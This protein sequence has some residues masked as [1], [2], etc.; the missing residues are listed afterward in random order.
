M[1]SLR[2]I[3]RGQVEAGGPGGPRPARRLAG[4]LLLFLGIWITGSLASPAL[5]QPP[6]A[7]PLKKAPAALD[8][9]QTFTILKI[10]PDAANEEVRIIFSHPVSLDSLRGNLRLLPFVKLDWRKSAAKEATVTL[11]GGFKY[12]TGYLVALPENLPAGGRTYNPTI[13]SFVMP[14]RPPK[15]EFVG[16]K[17]VIERDS[18]QL[19]HVKA[20]NVK[21]L[22]Y[23]GLRIPPLL[24]PLA[25]A[26]EENPADWDRTRED[27]K[28]GA[29]KLQALTRGNKSFLPFLT[30]PLEEKQLF[31]APA[32]KNRLMAVSL[33]LSFRQNKEAGALELIR[34]RQENGGAATVPRV[35]RVTDLGLTYKNGR[36]GLLIW[37]TSLKDGVPL[38]GVQVLGFTRDM[39]V[40]PL[41]QTDQDGILLFK[42]QEAQGLS[43]ADLAGIK[44]VKREVDKDQLVCLLAGGGRDFSFI[45]L[46]PQGNLKPEGIWQARVEDTIRSLKGQV[47]TER[48][49][50]RPGEKVFFKGV[51]REYREGRIAP[52]AEEVCAFEVTSPKDESVF[53]W[54]GTLSDFG[55]V[56]GEIP[57][58]SHWPL[59]TYT[60]N[61]TFGPQEETATESGRRPRGRHRRV[62]EGEAAKGP[63][64]KVTCTFQVQE[65]KPPRHF[66]SL[67]F[68]R[69]TRA[70]KGYVNQPDRTRE[71]VRIGLSGAYYVGGPVKH[72]QVIWKIY[73]ARTSYT[74]PAYDDFTFGYAGQEKK[75]LIEGGQAILDEKGRAEVEFP[76]EQAVL[77]GKSG[78]QVTATV[79]DFDG[80]SA[81]DS[82]TFQIDPDYLV[83]IS[84]HPDEISAGQD[85]V[86]KV[87]VTR[88][89]GKKIKTGLIRAEVL[90]QS[91]AYVAKRNDQ[92]D[93]YWDYQE[94]W[95]KSH[96]ADLPLKQGEA[97]FRFD[98]EWGGRYLVAF[99]YKDDKGRS[100]ASAT[101]FEVAYASFYEDRERGK[102]A[103][104]ELA[105]FP[106]RAA[107]KPGQTATIA[108]RPKG[109]VSRYLVTLEQGGLLSHQ[110]ITPG[111]GFKNLEIPIRKEY[112]P[113]VFVSVLAL[114]PRGDFPVAP[115]SYDTEA[116]NFFWGTLNLPVRLEVEPLEVK[117]SPE[118]KE[119]KAEPGSPFKLDFIVQDSKG[120]GVEAELAV[121]VVDEAVL[122]LTGFKTPVLDQLSRFDGPLGVYTGELRALLVHQTPFYLARNEPLTGGGGL[123]AEMAA[124]LRKRFEAVAYYNP[125]V[126]TDAKGR[127]QVSFTLPDNMTSYRVY[128]VA[129][130]RGARFASP[131]RTLKTPK[132]FYLEPG[133]PSFFTQGDR[134]TFQTAAFNQTAAAGPVKFRVAAEGGLSLKSEGAAAPL[135]A[136][137]SLKIPVSGEA[138]RAGPATARV[139]AEFQGRADSVELKLRVNSG[140]VRETTLFSGSLTGTREIKV[141]LPA[142]LT[143]EAAG[144]INPEEVKAVL[145]LS[146]SP[147]LRMAGAIQYLLTYPYGCVEQASSGVLALAALRGLIKDNQIEGV[148]LEQTDQYLGAGV[149]RI[150]SMQTESGGFGYWPGYREAHSLGSLYAVAALSVA[151]SQG[152]KVSESSLEKAGDYLKAQIQEPQVPDF[153]KAFACYL[154]ALNRTLDLNL[155]KRVSANYA[156]L[157]REGKIL[158]L[159]AGKES[160]LLK[161]EALKK[162]LGPLLGP[163]AAGE[164]QGDEFDARF[165]GPALA[166][167]AAKAIMPEDPRTKQAALFL[168]GGLDHQGIWT[169]TSDTGWALLALGEYYKGLT[170]SAEPSEVKV[171]QPGVKEGPRLTL[172]P[173]G[174]RTVGLE[175]QALLKNPV[176]RVEAKEGRTWLYKL[177][178]TAPRLDIAATG[179]DQGFK[180]RKIIKNT[181]GS[182]EIKVG[183]LVKVTVLIDVAG[184]QGRYV[185]LEDPLPAGLAAINSAFKTE[186]PLPERQRPGYDD[187]E[188]NGG[189][190]S[191]GDQFEYINPEG[192][193]AFRPNYFEIRDDRVLAFRDWVFQGP[194]RFEYYAR[195]VCQGQFAVPATKA[196]AM[197]SPG[198][199]GYSPQGTITIQG[200]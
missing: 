103:Y 79:V 53:T 124:R 148:T 127:A 71:F 14:D 25:L 50:Y 156:R 28:T 106:N 67:D 3:F 19:L 36:T 99:T 109:A 163:E 193:M 155:Y 157:N 17:S 61:M 44:A 37:V 95:R 91:W 35:F 62:V 48:G 52:P 63:Q 110:V 136:K 114:T 113:N 188:E 111:E 174:F 30:S 176:V 43:L 181:D 55:T 107:Y 76:L 131:E 130:D 194:Y 42:S 108:V 29:E 179:A 89:D 45:R 18:R 4:W 86:L 164:A 132:E 185:A 112:A 94:T 104:Q 1:Q 24:L 84:S 183:D 151:R 177:E 167:L 65:F 32:G 81:S 159:L 75:Y 126:R 74:V 182:A 189:G 68:K 100:F 97:E 178:L 7:R 198:V 142:Y 184:K 16:A 83:G 173:K 87:I 22:L 38:A 116:P 15:V 135:A 60:L 119:L 123:S 160:G 47:F 59:G 152:M 153:H 117:I 134:F 165:R 93:V 2:S 26:V 175:A 172:D 21:T 118:V 195:A 115:G 102:K 9:D 13:H 54:E 180:V 66:V 34:V 49:V 33:P 12:G 96:A 149:F 139:G 56:A 141:S 88:K 145:T 170:F 70:E 161:A 133:L 98:F 150:L 200:R 143:G 187:E 168:L 105:L 92:G 140:H 122:A 41:G 199:R 125:Q 166:L 39:E 80:R 129:V 8:K 137:D 162:G 40:F 69:V 46:S 191:N 90:Q 197:Y 169:S 128:A 154:L 192:V 78:L 101:P 144:K 58:E 190:V 23:E 5:S 72:G 57:T 171:S 85:Q 20:Q 147:F 31:P 73:R 51:V 64:N 77:Q 120:Q 138:L 82:Q 11:K 6:K 158:L 186:E 27:L 196:A 121:A 10:E 146:G